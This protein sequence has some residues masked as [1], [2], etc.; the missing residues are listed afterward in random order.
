MSEKNNPDFKIDYLKY[1]GSLEGVNPVRKIT[2]DE[3]KARGMQA[4]DV[5]CIGGLNLLISIDRG[6]DIL[7]AHYKGV[8][9]SFLSKNGF[10]GNLATNPHEEEFLRYFSGGMLTT[11]GLRSTGPSS[12]EETG[13]FHPLHGRI[14]TIP[15]TEV[16]CT[17]KSADIIEISGV[18][19]ETALFGCSL[20]LHRKIIIDAVNSEISLHDT[21]VNETAHDEE[22]MILYHYNFGYPFLQEG[23]RVEFE[24]SDSVIPRSEEAKKGMNDYME[25]T[26]PEDNYNEQ[27]FFHLQKGN[28]DG[29]ASVKVI[30]PKLDITATLKYKLDNLPIIA[31]W[32]SM[33]SGD[34]ALGLEPSNNYIMGRMDER[35]N[36]TIKTIEAYGKL[37]YFTSL[38]FS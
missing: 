15:A 24:K 36:K 32:K 18:I 20:A 12:R 35:E 25:I 17:R 27:V 30:N 26:A 3:G 9:M 8:N 14:N 38:Q 21:L 10:T 5:R 4:Y 22:I 1:A 16:S 11:C 34:Y 13:E 29:I 6:L 37:E 31:Q 33:R 23:C 7:S 2:F 28:A 19:R